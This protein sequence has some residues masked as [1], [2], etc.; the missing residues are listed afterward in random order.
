MANAPQAMSASSGTAGPGWPDEINGGLA[1]LL[2]DSHMISYFDRQSSAAMRAFQFRCVGRLLGHARRHSPW[3]REHLAR[4]DTHAPLNFADLPL[5]S[6]QVFRAALAA[7]GALPV[8]PSH[9]AISSAATSGST[10]IPLS[11]YSSGLMARMN[12][13]QYWQ[14]RIRQ[15]VDSRRRIARFSVHM[16][17]H[18]SDHVA[19][20]PNAVLGKG[21][22][23][24]RRPQLFSM[25]QHAR[26]VSEVQPAYIISHPT[27]LSGIMDVFEDG[28]FS[29]PKVEA[30]LTFAESLR[31]EF[32]ARARTIF[33]ARTIDRYS[34]QEVGPIAFQCPSS[35]EH[36]HVASSHV[37]VEV[38]DGAGKP[39]PDGQLGRVYVTSLHNYASPTIRYELGDLAAML[40]RC[41]C[42]HDQPVLTNILGR[43]RFLIK[44]PGGE[45]L[46]VNFGARHWFKIAPVSEHRLVQ[47][48]ALR[49]EAEYVMDRPMTAAEEQALVD[50]LRAEISPQIDYVVKRLDKIA[51]GPT[52]KRQDVVSLI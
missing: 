27:V 23:L 26:W 5:M 45:R 11:F 30:L 29:P 34:S 17:E 4:L 25:E 20:A 31:P 18:A 46:Y 1:R 37:L 35:D 10:G 42:G 8:P 50:L 41:P 44:L 51:W 32:R 21:V 15:G 6:R 48:E 22:E 3:W 43:E 52:Y 28:K 49:I 36:Y 38:L 24:Q 9:G 40:P 39:M 33:G 19:S 7:G 47:T 14:D 2:V 16:D 13:A 12:Q